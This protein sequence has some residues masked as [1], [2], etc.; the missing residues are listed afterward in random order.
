MNREGIRRCRPAVSSAGMDSRGRNQVGG[1]R[2]EKLR[3]LQKVEWLISRTVVAY[4]LWRIPG[5]GPNAR[6]GAQE[7]PGLP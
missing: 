2:K 3:G 5:R 1:L 6:S 7:A 4:N